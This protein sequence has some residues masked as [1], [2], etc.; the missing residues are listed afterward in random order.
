MSLQGSQNGDSS[1][2]S[3]P[4]SPATPSLTQHPH[5]SHSSRE[6]SLTLPRLWQML[7]CLVLGT[8]RGGGGAALIS[9]ITNGCL[10]LSYSHE[11]G[12]KSFRQTGLGSS[13][14]LPT[15]HC[16]TLGKFF[17]LSELPH[18]FLPHEISKTKYCKGKHS[19]P[20]RCCPV[21]GIMLLTSSYCHSANYVTAR[22]GWVGKAGGVGNGQG[23]RQPLKLWWWEGGLGWD[24]E[25]LSEGPGDGRE[26]PKGH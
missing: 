24:T 3:A 16:V 1:H 23:R 10:V 7:W 26:G 17:S 22:G 18:L 4:A 9:K 6:P 11:G 14:Y 2:C 8:P 12:N 5:H 13:S 15:A 20:V 25:C 19:G 21:P